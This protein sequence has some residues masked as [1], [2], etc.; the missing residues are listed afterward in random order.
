MCYVVYSVASFIVCGVIRSASSGLLCL[1][2]AT[3]VLY[4]V[5]VYYVY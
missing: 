5:Y 1:L 2:I 3:A 4:P